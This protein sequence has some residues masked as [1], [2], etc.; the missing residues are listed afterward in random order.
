MIPVARSYGGAR[1]GRVIPY[2][3]ITAAMLLDLINLPSAEPA[4]KMPSLML[5][6]LFFWSLVRPELVSTFTIFAFGIVNDVVAGLPIGLSSLAMLTGI[7]VFTKAGREFIAASFVVMWGCFILVS[8]TTYSVRW[9]VASMWWG[10][11]FSYQD[12]VIEATITIAL[13]PLINFL[14]SALENEVPRV[15]HASGE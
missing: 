3:M 8:I 6:S 14:G 1:F 12:A 5:A 11:V 15:A 4:A 9:I 10:H 13:F 7:K 2:A